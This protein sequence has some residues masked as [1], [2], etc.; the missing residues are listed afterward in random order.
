MK[1]TNNLPVMGGRLPFTLIELLVVIAIIAILAAMLLPALSAA[2]ERARSANCTNNLKNIGLAISVY[3]DINQGA[4]ISY[5]G[6]SAS[7]GFWNYNLQESN[8]LP[9]KDTDVSKVFYCP[10]SQP[11]SGSLLYTYGMFCTVVYQPIYIFKIEDPTNHFMVADSYKTDIASP[12]YRMG[13]TQS[14]A[15]ASPYMVHGKTCNMLFVAGHVE[16]VNKERLKEIPFVEKGV[17]NPYKYMF[18]EYVDG[19]GQKQTL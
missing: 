6:A 12:Y 5:S 19:A 3:S 16:S 14:N 18:T 2:R 17:I 10:S 1:K 13:A 11:K 15:Q 4:I 8:S 9:G 7:E